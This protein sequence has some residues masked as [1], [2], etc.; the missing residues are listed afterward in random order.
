MLVVINNK[1]SKLNTYIQNYLN[2]QCYYY[3]TKLL[4]IIQ[5][6]QFLNVKPCF[7]HQFASIK[8]IKI[9]VNFV[10]CKF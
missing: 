1:K 6:I 8:S 5:N 2:N 7:L 10:Y 9:L 3:L 4:K